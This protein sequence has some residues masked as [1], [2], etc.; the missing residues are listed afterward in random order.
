MGSSA[1]DV[2]AAQVPPRSLTGA[3]PPHRMRLVVA[4]R[5]ASREVGVYRMR[6]H[7]T[8]RAS[9][10]PPSPRRRFG[11]I[12]GRRLLAPVL[13]ITFVLAGCTSEPAR[14]TEGPPPDGFETWEAFYRAEDARTREIESNAIKYDMHRSR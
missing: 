12:T 13:L 6:I 10:I 7:R 5:A 9:S 4:C 8:P 3:I 11:A 2:R 1:D 14:H